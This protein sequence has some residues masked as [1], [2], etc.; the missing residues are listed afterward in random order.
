M[1][2]AAAIALQFF[3]QEGTEE[4]HERAHTNTH[5]TQNMSS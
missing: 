2:P 1:G 3:S 5:I 4:E